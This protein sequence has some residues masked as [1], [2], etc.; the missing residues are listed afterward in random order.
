MRRLQKTG[1]RGF[2]LVELIVVI[3]LMGL[4]ATISIGG[5]FAAARGMAAR[6]VVQ[7]TASLVRQAMQTCLIDQ[8][9]TAVLFLNR[10]NNT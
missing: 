6:G 1:T 8:V 4:L 9:P 3:G 5:Y 2:T 10:R 7:D